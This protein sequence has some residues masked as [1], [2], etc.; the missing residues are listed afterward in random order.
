MDFQ[1]NFSTIKFYP[2]T[3]YRDLYTKDGFLVAL[4]MWHLALP[5]IPIVWYEAG[6]VHQQIWNSRDKDQEDITCIIMFHFQEQIWALYEE[7]SP[8]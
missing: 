5:Y 1:L 3:L 6:G 8:K 2:L 4:F 7:H